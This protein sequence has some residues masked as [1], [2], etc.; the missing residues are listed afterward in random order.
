[1]IKTS[2]IVIMPARWQATRKTF[3]RIDSPAQLYAGQ[4]YP[5][6]F[7]AGPSVFDFTLLVE[8]SKQGS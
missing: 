6:S 1:L 2:A 8:Q 7:S 3:T 4:G 5:L